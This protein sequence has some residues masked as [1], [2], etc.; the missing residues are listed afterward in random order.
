MEPSINEPALMQTVKEQFDN[1]NDF[2]KYVNE[3]YKDLT[4]YYDRTNRIY[5]KRNFQKDSR[6]L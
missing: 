3:F 6:T 5:N 4:N 1:H 2:I